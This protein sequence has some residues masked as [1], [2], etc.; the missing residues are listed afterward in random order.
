[1][2]EKCKKE[3]NMEL[4]KF[5]VETAVSVT[6]L[7][8]LVFLKFFQHINDQAFLIALV[9]WGLFFPSPHQWAITIGNFLSA[10]KNNGLTLKAGKTGGGKN[11]EKEN[12]G[13]L[14]ESDSGNGA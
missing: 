7:L 3:P 8:V 10:R 5:I 13:S 12:A 9:M 4:I 11:N 6:F 1:M 14:P 2:E